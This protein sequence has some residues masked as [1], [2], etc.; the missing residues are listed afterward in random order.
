VSSQSCYISPR[1]LPVEIRGSYV[2]F[3]ELRQVARSRSWSF[4]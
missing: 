4:F 2:L 1:A 3:A